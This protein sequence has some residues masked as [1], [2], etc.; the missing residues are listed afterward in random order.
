ML[1]GPCLLPPQEPGAAA[2]SSQL[3]KTEALLALATGFQH[4]ER[5]LIECLTC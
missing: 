5:M 2:R 3:G 4:G 1:V